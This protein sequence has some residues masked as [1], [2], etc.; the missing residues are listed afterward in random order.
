MMTTTFAR[1]R[2]LALVTATAVVLTVGLMGT[3]GAASLRPPAHGGTHGDTMDMDEGHHHD[4]GDHGENAPT[5][6]GARKIVVKAKSFKFRPSTITMAP[7]EDVTLVLR[8]TDIVHD[9][10]VKD[11]GHIVS[12]KGKK[13]A[14]GGLEIDEPGTYAF[15]CSVSGHRKAGMRGMIVVTDA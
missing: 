5:V 8:S 13:S 12:A 4:S 15:W 9:L 1:R 10:V 7:G 14:S 6:D 11:E 3:S 2:P